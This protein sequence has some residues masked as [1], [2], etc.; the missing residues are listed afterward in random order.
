MNGDGFN[1]SDELVL[2]DLTETYPSV[3]LLGY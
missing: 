1:T 2:C 3:L